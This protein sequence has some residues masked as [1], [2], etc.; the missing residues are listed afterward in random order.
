MT[1]R[2]DPLADGSWRV[3]IQDRGATSQHVVTVPPG[4]AEELGYDRVSD[5]DLV[6][7]S[8]AFL[9]DREPASSILPRFPLD[10]IG[11]YF[12]DYAASIGPYLRTP[13]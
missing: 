2:V 3:R 4:Y 1:V 10:V 7:A 5:A 9:L 11:R 12:P 6:R 8:F 13:W